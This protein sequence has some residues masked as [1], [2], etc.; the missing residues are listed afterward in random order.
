VN[1]SKSKNRIQTQLPVSVTLIFAPLEIKKSPIS[2]YPYI[3]A[4]ISGVF[5]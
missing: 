1:W 5:P 3:A 4:S 2:V